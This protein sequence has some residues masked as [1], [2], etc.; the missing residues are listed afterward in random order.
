MDLQ[1]RN[2]DFLW[3]SEGKLNDVSNDVTRGTI[4][5]KNYCKYCLSIEDS[6]VASNERG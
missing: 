2:M 6:V 3:G 1:N 5:G 4:L